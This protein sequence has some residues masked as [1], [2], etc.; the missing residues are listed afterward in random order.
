MA[1]INLQGGYGAGGAVD[2]LRVLVAEQLRAKTQADQVAQE[3]ARL[4]EAQA[5][6][7]ED[8]RQFNELQPIRFGNLTIGQR[9]AT[10]NETNAGL[11]ASDAAA[12]AA[13]DQQDRA[14]KAASDAAFEEAIKSLPPEAQNVA[15]LNK[16][17][18]RNVIN[19]ADLQPKTPA[20]ARPIEISNMLQGG[21]V[22]TGLVD[23]ETQQATGFFETRQPAPKESGLTP[24][25]EMLA[26]NKLKTDWDNSTNNYRQ[27]KQ[28]SALMQAGLDAAKRGDM[29][30]GSQAVLVTFQK[31]LDPTSVVRE[32]EY[33]RS[34]SGQAV[35]ARIQGFADK[36]A[37]GGAGV[38]VDELEKFAALGKDFIKAADSGLAGRRARLERDAKHFNIDPALI[39]DTEAGMAPTA[40]IAPP[41]ATGVATSGAIGARVRVKGPNGET[42]TMPADSALPPGWTKVGG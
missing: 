30:A 11:R 4:A 5:R 42:G 19:L 38:P 24:N 41:G 7:G 34:A 35:M 2:A 21:K 31:I 12:K 16:N 25:Q 14:A 27:M 9:D 1:G 20:K 22:G 40:S 18:G 29:A 33:A 6:R 32:S 26:I 15:R 36:L 37:Q 23:P 10:V 39:F 17:A 3:Q 28:Q 13:A 8:A